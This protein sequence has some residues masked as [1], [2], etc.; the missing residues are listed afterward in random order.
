MPLFVETD[1]VGFP[2]IAAEHNDDNKLIFYH[3]FPLTR[4]Q[5]EEA[6]AKGWLAEYMQN[7]PDNTILTDI[8]LRGEIIFESYLL[9]EKNS[10]LSPEINVYPG[11]YDAVS[12]QIRCGLNGI[13]NDNI[14][15]IYISNLRMREYNSLINWLEADKFNGRLPNIDDN[16][17]YQAFDAFTINDMAAKIL[18]LFNLNNRAKRM[19]KLYCNLFG[20]KKGLPGNI[21]EM[22]QKYQISGVGNFCFNPNAHI[23]ED[24][25]KNM[26]PEIIGETDLWPYIPVKNKSRRIMAENHPIVG[27]RGVFM[28][29]INVLK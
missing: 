1:R 11:K 26:Q 27:T 21:L 29:K 13:T 10:P 5:F 22:T 25:E 6:I 16:K 7:N 4:I 20:N 9:L 12:R 14:Q 18:Q 17:N 15:S 19:I 23:N 28:K 3:F 8:L 2:L 24:D